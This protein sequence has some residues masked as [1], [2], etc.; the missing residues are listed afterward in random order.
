MGISGG[1][2]SPATTQGSG[3]GAGWACFQ[4]VRA[5]LARVRH[6]EVLYGLPCG[7][8][9]GDAPT[10]TLCSKHQLDQERSISSIRRTV[11]NE[12]TISRRRLFA[13]AGLAV[14][15]AVAIPAAVL[16][17]SSEAEAQTRRRERVEERPGGRQ[18]R[19]TKRRTGE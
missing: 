6:G 19:R 12:Q 18:E 7:N 9:A 2:R 8:R 17:A 10:R 4:G 5:T 1:C 3:W 11:M 16:T 13:L 15:T 14:T